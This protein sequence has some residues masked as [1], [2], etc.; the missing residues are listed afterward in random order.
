MSS[1]KWLIPV[2]TGIRNFLTPSI[3]LVRPLFIFPDF[4][5]VFGMNRRGGILPAKFHRQVA[6]GHAPVRAWST[7]NDH[8]PINA[9]KAFSLSVMTVIT[10][11]SSSLPRWFFPSSIKSADTTTEDA[12]WRGRPHP[13]ILSLANLLKTF[14]NKNQTI[15]GKKR[16]FP[17]CSEVFRTAIWYYGV[18]ENRAYFS[19]KTEK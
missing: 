3:G 7:K 19:A 13:L 12:A 17:F 18:V 4:K 15:D 2:R 6:H 8:R 11:H 9:Q 1:T 14:L 10:L 16:H 5:S